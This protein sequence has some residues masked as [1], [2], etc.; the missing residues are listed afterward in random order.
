MRWIYALAIGVWIALAVTATLNGTIRTYG[1]G[2][3]MSEKTAHQIS[4]VTGLL[5]FAG[6]MYLF[7]R[8]SPFE[9]ERRDLILIGIM[10]VVMTIVFEFV[11]G[12]FVFGNPWSKLFHDYNILEGRVWILVPIWTAIGPYVMEIL[13]HPRGV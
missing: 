7:L 11:F 12:H 5:L 3:L 6:V 1:Y 2:T 4:T 10:W 8:F 13:T 9:Y